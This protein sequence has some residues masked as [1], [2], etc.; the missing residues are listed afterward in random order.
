ML[1]AD[2]R[3]KTP[4]VEGRIIVELG[5]R[6][7]CIKWDRHLIDGTFQGPWVYFASHSETCETSLLNSTCVEAKCREELSRDEQQFSGS[8]FDKLR[9]IGDEFL[10]LL[11][12]DINE[13]KS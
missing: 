12:K 13:T 10:R 1:G 2:P 4:I 6:L 9:E 3:E 8:E 11:V 5:K 7:V